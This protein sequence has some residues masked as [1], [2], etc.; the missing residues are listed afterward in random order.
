KFNGVTVIA[1]SR[2]GLTFAELAILGE[3]VQLREVKRQ[4][5]YEPWEQPWGEHRHIENRFQQLTA[6][7]LNGDEQ[8]VFTLEVRVFNDGLGFRYQVPELI[9]GPVSLIDELTQF[10]LLDASQTDAWWIPARE[11]NRYEYLYDETK[12]DAM[13]LVHTPVT[14]RQA[15]GVHLSIH[16]AA[17]VDYAAMSLKQE[18]TGVLKAD[19]TPWSD[20][21]LVKTSLPLSTPWRTIQIADSATGLLN[22]ALS[23]N[24]NEPNELG[25]V[26]WV[27]PG[28]YIGIWWGMHINKNTWG[29]GPIHGATTSEA[30]RYIDFAANHGFDGVLIEGWNIG[31]DG[32][33]FFNGEVFSFTEAYPDFDIKAVTGYARERGVQLIGHHETSGNVTNYEAQMEDAFAMYE[34]VGVTQVKTGYVADGGDIVRHTPEGFKR[35]EWH[36]GQYTVNHYLRNVRMAAE[37]KISINTHEPIKDTGLRRT[38]PNWISREGA[39]GQEF[40]AWGS[41][42]NT[43]S[44]IPTLAFTR[45]LAG[46]MDFTPGIVDM[47]FNGLDGWNRPQTTVAKQLASYVVIYSPIQ[48]AA[49][50][51]ENYRQH[52][53]ALEFIESVVTDWEQSLAL[54]GEVGEFV[55]QARQERGG[56]RWFIGG[57]TN[58]NSR[59]LALPLSFLSGGQRYTLTLYRDAPSTDWRTNPA[60]LIRESFTVTKDST[61][62]IN[63]VASGGFAARLTPL[64]AGE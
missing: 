3:G 12:A 39:R 15:N 25:D 54:A 31:W 18:R 49:D 5:R 42:P 53:M 57:L 62:E 58:E 51:P 55:V 21:V 48:M 20:G 38:Y 64:L 63:M 41:P 40:N 2:L 56:E 36:D 13:R 34:A 16:E 43:P 45:L 10:V 47:T 37:H 35:H 4:H 30:K 32:D 44:H 33:W 19:L 26:S 11:W 46:P 7:F 9:E 59:F 61:L 6:V 14:L 8:E 27:E 52:P 24:L 50:L 22:S 17:L 28:K 29:S 60:E 1:P 23:L